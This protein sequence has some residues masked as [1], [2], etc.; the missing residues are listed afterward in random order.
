VLARSG[1]LEFHAGNLL[2]EALASLG[3]RGGGSADLAQGQ[4]P[5]QQIEAL[6]DAI[7]SSV[8][9]ATGQTIAQA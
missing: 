8:R 4:V 9:S 1:D 5:L 7:G 2:K 3:L 6:L